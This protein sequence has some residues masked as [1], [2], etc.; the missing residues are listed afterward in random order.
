MA[1]FKPLSFKALGA[2]IDY[3]KVETIDALD[4]IE[5][6]LA[7]DE[8]L[9]R[10]VRFGLAALIETLRR[11]DLIDLQ[12]DWLALFDRSRALSLHLYQHVH[13]ESRDRGQ[14]MVSLGQ[15]YASH[16]LDLTASELPDYLPVLCEFLSCVPA[17]VSQPLLADAAHIIE[18][19][20]LR[21][22][23]KG[24]PHAAV[25]AALQAL[26]PSRIDAAKVA[27]VI[28][29]DQIEDVK[30]LAALDEEWEEKPV[31]FGPGDAAAGCA[32]LRH[33]PIRPAA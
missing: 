25:F 15:L 12:E 2:L 16:G 13:G 20:R 11:G 3:P 31:T 19:I 23:R 24:S 32:S 14:A 1:T 27:E 5:T 26:A 33:P 29:A 17:E 22:V 9:P 4:A 10:D 7:T 8:V 6:V 28:E 21:L 18:A 30:D